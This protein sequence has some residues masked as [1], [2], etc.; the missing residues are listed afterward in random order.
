MAWIPRLTQEFL[1]LRRVYAPAASPEGKAVRR[2]I[3]ELTEHNPELPGLDDQIQFRTPLGVV[4]ARPIARTNLLL[5]YRFEP[6]VV[7]IHAVMPAAW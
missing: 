2:A 7:H 5:L 4:Y 1:R 6:P 3:V